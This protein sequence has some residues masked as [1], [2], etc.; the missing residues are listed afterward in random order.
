V[1][2]GDFGGWWVRFEGEDAHRFCSTGGLSGSCY[3]LC[4]MR[5]GVVGAEKD[6][7]DT[8]VGLHNKTVDSVCGADIQDSSAS[9]A[10]TRS[11]PSVESVNQDCKET[12]DSCESSNDSCESKMSSK[13]LATSPLSF[14]PDVVELC[15]EEGGG[16][17]YVRTIAH[18][19]EKSAVQ[20]PCPMPAVWSI[21][22]Q[23]STAYTHPQTQTHDVSR[24]PA[25]PSARPPPP[26]PRLAPT[27]TDLAM[28]N[29]HMAPVNSPSSTEGGGDTTRER[30]LDVRREG[31]REMVREMVGA[32]WV[33]CVTPSSATAPR[34]LIPEATYKQ[35]FLLC[36]VSHEYGMYVCAFPCMRARAYMLARV[37]VCVCLLETECKTHTTHTQS[38]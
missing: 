21:N 33:R 17:G 10:S 7:N 8:S 32:R 29:A 36:E 26:P 15:G 23:Y 9:A 13:R 11:W 6:S 34:V 20:N 4:K 12:P 28:T 19:H 25:S 37:N 35:R 16:G 27:Y 14:L 31:G 22:Q 30:E 18:Q 24:S 5:P 1:R 3:E 38:P 2:K